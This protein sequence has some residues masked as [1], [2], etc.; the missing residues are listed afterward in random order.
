[1]RRSGNNKETGS[2][3]QRQVTGNI[4]MS[5]LLYV[6]AVFVRGQSQRRTLTLVDKY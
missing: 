1:M 6:C 3:S 2:Q 4:A 5:F